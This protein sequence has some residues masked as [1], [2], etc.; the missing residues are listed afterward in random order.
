MCRNKLQRK[1]IKFTYEGRDRAAIDEGGVVAGAGV[2]SPEQ[3]SRIAVAGER[4]AG[5]G[6]RIAGAGERI[7]GA[8]WGDGYMMLEAMDCILGL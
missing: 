5:A 3:G 6:E 1:V 7:A 8:E 2:E 4:I